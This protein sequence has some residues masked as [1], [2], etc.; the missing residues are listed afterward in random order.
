VTIVHSSTSNSDAR[1]PADAWRR[2]WLLAALLCVA[3]LGLWEWTL[4][5]LGFTPIVRND[6]R[7][8]RVARARVTPE[9][10]V[11]LGTSRIQSAVDPAAWAEAWPESGVP[12]QLAVA[13]GSPLPVLDELAADP[14]FRGLAVVELLPR[15][16]FDASGDSERDSVRMLAGWHGEYGRPAEM[17]ESLLQVEVSRRVTFRSLPTRRLV[18]RAFLRE[19]R[20]APPYYTMDARRF[21][22]LDFER[23]DVDDRVA[24]ITENI[25]RRGRPATDDEREAILERIERA[26]AAIRSRGGSVVFVHL[27]HSGAVR[28][29]EERRY[30]PERYWRS[31]VERNIAPV[32]HF[33]RD[34]ELS[35]FE[36]P[37]GSHIDRRRTQAFTRVLVPRV[38]HV[39]DGG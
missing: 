32:I 38:R 12:V 34:R 19:N 15:M 13:G 23:A 21:L 29:I 24:E 18:Y 30:P 20:P 14:S 2:T 17:A 3:V 35:R 4:R 26:V 39:L 27:P 8:W 16:V 6:P 9:G 10:T 11:L 25:S 37:D 33:E 31:F 1:R 7:A 36:L 22:Q 28:E 5:D